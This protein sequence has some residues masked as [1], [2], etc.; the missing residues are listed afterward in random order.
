MC[1]EESNIAGRFGG[2]MEIPP[3]VRRRATAAEGFKLRAGNTSACAEKR[4]TPRVQRS[5]RR[6]Y[7]RVCGEEAR[8]M[9]VVSESGEIPPRVRRRVGGLVVPMMGIV[10]PWAV[11]TAVTSPSSVT[12]G[13][14]QSWSGCN[15]R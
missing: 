7:L 1:G 9:T 8:A 10:R 12:S 4:H 15:T 11:P 13:G 2:V 3:R 14:I 5:H 6:K